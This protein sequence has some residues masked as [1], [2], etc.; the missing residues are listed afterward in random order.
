MIHHLISVHYNTVFLVLLLGIKLYTRKQSRDV[1]LKYYWLTLICCFLLVIQDALESYTAEDP[2][3]IFWRTLLSALGYILRPTAAVSLVLVVCPPSRRTWII[4]IPWGVNLLVNLTAFF[5]P[6]AFSF[7]ENYEFTRGP[8]GYV[9][10][11]V[12]LLYM[13]WILVLVRKRLYKGKN[14][15]RWILIICV[16]GCMCASVVDALYGGS[17]LNEAMMIAGVFL[18][19]YLRSHDNYLDPLTS[20]RNRYALYDDSQEQIR[21]VCAAA[22]IDM[23]GLKMINDTKGHAAG[24]AALAE[25]GRCLNGISSRNVIPYRIGG[26]EYTVLFLHC[27]EEKI[28]EL[29]ARV[30]EEIAGCGYHVSIGYAMKAPGQSL[31]ELMHEADRHMYED[32]AAWY[33]QNGRD[34][35][36]RRQS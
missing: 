25:I 36:N 7:N 16:L 17:H 1:E 10:F 13:I 5:S 33:R 26:D 34:R 24:D 31:D 32:K 15:E 3:L 22:S 28:A 20:L 27:T 8:L 21:E 14:G 9:V 23:N 30:K 6:I 29:L 35:R 12:S 18:F 2:G 19:M 11:V 4:W